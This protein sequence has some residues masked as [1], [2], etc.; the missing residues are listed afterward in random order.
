[1]CHYALE[2]YHGYG[3]DPIEAFTEYALKERQKIH[4][5]MAGKVP[6]GFWNTMDELEDLGRNILQHYLLHIKD[7]SDYE[8][9]YVAT[10]YEFSVPIPNQ[11]IYLTDHCGEYYPW[12]TE[13]WGQ[14]PESHEEFIRLYTSRGLVNV[15]LNPD[16]TIL[17]MTIPPLYV[18]RLDGLVRDRRGDIWIID[19]KFMA[20]LVDRE[21]L[22]LDTQTARYVWAATVA[23]KRGWW[24]GISPDARIRGALYNVVRKKVPKVPRVLKDGTTSKSKIDTTYEI[25]RSVLVSRKENPNDF[26]EILLNLRDGGNK[27]FQL[28]EIERRP[29]EL[30]LMGQKLGYEYEDMSR[31]ASATR[32]LLHPILYPSPNRDCTWACS[33]KSICYVANWGGDVDHI[34]Q[35]TMVPQKRTDLYATQL[36]AEPEEI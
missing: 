12:V 8:F 19:H 14:T 31:V 36:E 34:I 32:D 25:F 6:P 17:C 18:G 5:N 30:D 9:E 1:M 27:F 10:E 4:E 7:N 20:Q 33:F 3:E 24:E 29:Q 13:R 15:D 16:G 2:R 21:M 26:R 23:I 28:L 22:T 35:A 11:L